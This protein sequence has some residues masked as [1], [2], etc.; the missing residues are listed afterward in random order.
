MKRD[1]LSGA[2]ITLTAVAA[3]FLSVAATAHPGGIAGDGCH[4]HRA[5]D[6]CHCHRT[7]ASRPGCTEWGEGG[8]GSIDGAEPG[9]GGLPAGTSPPAAGAPPAPA[10]WIRIATWNLNR[11]HWRTGGALWRGA[12]ARNGEDYE[13]LARYARVLD[14]DVIAFQEVNGPRAAARV[15]PSRDY[16]LYFS[17]RYDSRYDDIYNGFAVRKSR[18]DH[19]EKRDYEA[20]GLGSGARYQLRWGVDLTVRRDGQD[21]RLLNVHLK[22]KCFAK[23]LENPR[24]RHCRKLARQVDPLESWID[25][26]WREGAPF[27]VLGDFNRA[28]D[29]HGSRDHLWRAI[30]DGDP[31]GLKLHRLPAGREP[32]CWRGTPRHHRHPIDFFVFG[33]RAW[34]RVDEA[35]F[36]QVVWTDR[37][38]DARRGL[39]SDHCPIAVD[40]F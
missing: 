31:P 20:L 5:N 28:V 34:R 33:A 27:V 38:A 19:V 37:D 29:R 10:E 23:S 21:L 11:L 32:A 12:V 36:R 18:F 16:A 25:A 40:L 22:S 13:T 17:G 6:T 35:S 7:G 8:H 3:A 2:L 30:D 1:A 39:P 24:D 14:A 15:F 26:R 9:A 4:D